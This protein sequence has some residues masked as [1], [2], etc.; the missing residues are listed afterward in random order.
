MTSP[1]SK[2]S[3]WP[4]GSFQDG[5]HETTSEVITRQPVRAGSEESLL[6]GNESRIYVQDY[7]V[8][9]FV[10]LLDKWIILYD[11]PTRVLMD[12][13][14]QFFKKFFQS[15][16]TFFESKHLKT[17]AY[18]PQSDEKVE[19]FNERNVARLRHYMVE[20]QQDRDIYV[21]LLTSA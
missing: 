5:Q 10:S 11:I 2:F 17:T 6:E 3:K 1:T 12:N 15:L 9:H 21:Q 20:H 8:A 19:R 16:R 4:I 7:Y 18:R 14:T 13:G